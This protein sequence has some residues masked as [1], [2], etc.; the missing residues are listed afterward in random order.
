[1]RKIWVTMISILLVISLLAGCSSGGSTPA[2]SEEGAAGEQIVLRLGHATQTTHPF[3][4]GADKFAQL[5]AERSNDRIKIEIFPARQL[6][7]DR[8]LLEQVMGNTV[9]MAVV[10]S[11][12]FN[13]YTPLLDTLQLPFL[14]N[15]YEKELK[16]I[17]SN[18][19]KD[20]LNAL[21]SLNLQGLAVFEG[22][23]R[24]IANN[25]KPI[26]SPADLKGLKLRVVP[27]N[28]I[29]D[30]LKALGAN[31]TPMAYGEVYTGLQTN[32]IDGEEIN[33]TSIYSEKHYEVLKYFTEVGL[34]PFPGV[35]V[36]NKER[37][38]SLSA[39]DQQLIQDAAWETMEYVIGTYEE[40]EKTA[41]DTAKANKVEFNTISDVT[42]F[43][44]LVQ[45]IYDAH[46]QKDP[47]IK[48]FVDMANSL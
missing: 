38:D 46:I 21:D 26:H 39:E 40:L 37:M 22:G 2:P 10:S 19:M 7:D 23:M 13:S 32:V 31:P 11:P 17:T 14:L 48:K 28:L 8:E 24:H 44:E 9:D 3:H 16:A 12:L 4:L 43:K 33:L 25:V 42:P 18:E 30:T 45:P 15:S 27:S 6:G 36:M 1:M 34:F 29:I 20:I 47:L 5:V 41:V 35:A